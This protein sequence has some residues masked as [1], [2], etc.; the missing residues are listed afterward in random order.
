MKQPKRILI[1]RTDRLGDVVLSTPVIRFM[2]QAYP[3][4]YIAFMV[5]P[6][7]RDVVANNPHLDEIIVYDKRGAQRSFWDTV[8]FAFDLRRKRFDIAVALHPTNRAHIML[9]LAG[10]PVRIGY[11]RKM[12]WL[13]TKRIPHRKQEGGKHEVD[14][15]FDL[16]EQSGFDVAHLDRRPYMRTTDND[17]RLIDSMQKSFGI[18]KDIIA[19]HAGASCPSK[20]WFPERFAR[21]ADILGEKYQCDIVLVGGDDTAEYSGIVASAMKHKVTDLT[22][23]LLVGELAELISR[24]KI[25]ISNDSG[26]VHVAVAVGTPAVAIFGRKESGLSPGR[27]G[28]LGERDAVLHKPAGCEV[29]L[30][31]NCERDFAC[32]KAITVEDVVEASEKILRGS[33]LG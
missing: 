27:W 2:R 20:R 4:S 15:N 31:H 9:F 30:A 18:G 19:V 8:K 28:P 17:K 26:P 10:I 3:D 24:C 11:R 5:R 6:E 16:L 14:Y 25:F 7:N 22:G 1:T 29:C 21:V 32:L 23:M 12:S 13:L 33:F